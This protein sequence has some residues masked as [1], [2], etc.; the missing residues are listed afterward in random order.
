MTPPYA[1]YL[2]VYEPLTAFDETER[3]HWKRYVTAGRIPARAQGP[4][5]ER[6]W[7]LPGVLRMPPH[8]P[9]A[10]ELPEHAF[11]TQLDGRVVVCPWRTAVRCWSAVADLADLLPAELVTVVLP[12]SVAGPA[13]AANAAWSAEHE[14]RRTHIQAQRWA[15]PVRWFLLFDP[16]ERQLQLGTVTAGPSPVRTGRSVVYQT[17]MAQARRRAARAL[18]V[19]RRALG[20]S[21][22]VA[23]LEDVARWLEEFH[24]RSLVEL[25]YGGLV[26][27]LNDDILR[28][29]DSARDAADALDALARSDASG[30]AS[31]YDRII[32]RWQAASLIESAN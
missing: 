30:A 18:S 22:A 9:A 24:P 4:A 2:R 16:A 26:H 29:D 12:E 21:P 14:E 31:A 15:V 19:M 32:T 11:V 23:A 6:S 20:N 28:G 7:I 8:V 27:L 10:G 13:V 5:L 3:A 25:D 17:P 1:A